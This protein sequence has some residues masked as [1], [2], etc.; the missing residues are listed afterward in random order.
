MTRNTGISARRAKPIALG[1]VHGRNGSP[2]RVWGGGAPERS[3]PDSRA[4]VSRG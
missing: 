1:I 4:K 2:A 3:R